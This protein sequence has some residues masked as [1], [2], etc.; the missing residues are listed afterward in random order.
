M[1]DYSKWTDKYPE[2]PITVAEQ[3]FPEPKLFQSRPNQP[4]PIRSA[5]NRARLQDNDD[6]QPL[7]ARINTDAAIRE[8][9]E[10]LT[11]MAPSQQSLMMAGMSAAISHLCPWHLQRFLDSMKDLP[12]AADTADKASESMYFMGHSDRE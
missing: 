1:P 9:G 2:K 4:D 8:L 3:R 11:H 6:E 5:K 7:G 10:Y 12:V